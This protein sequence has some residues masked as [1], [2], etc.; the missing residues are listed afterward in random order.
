MVVLLVNGTGLLPF[1]QLTILVPSAI[2]L[3]GK[4]KEI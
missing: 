3:A 2:W 1:I 4:L